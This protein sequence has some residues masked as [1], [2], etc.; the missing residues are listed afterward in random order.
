MK[1]YN[2]AYMHDGSIVVFEHD[3]DP[4]TTAR[5]L[6]DVA[7]LETTFLGRDKQSEDDTEKGSADRAGGFAGNVERQLLEDVVAGGEQQYHVATG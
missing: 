2:R 5:S 6:G 7:R 1:S 4:M 3:G